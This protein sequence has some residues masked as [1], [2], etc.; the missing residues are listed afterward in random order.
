MTNIELISS[1][2]IILTLLLMLYPSKKY[3]DSVKC[4]FIKNYDGDTITVYINKI[5][6]FIGKEINIRIAGIDTPE[7]KGTT[8]NEHKRAI[9]AK[10]L[11][12]EYCSSARKIE[13]RNIQQGKYFRLVAQVYCDGTDIG[14]MLIKKGL[15]EPYA[16]GTK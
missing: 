10:N 2:V 12:Y 16:G 6:D 15:A 4:K 11:V 3:P 14:L 13:L 8:G 1:I 9:K 7:L 5:P